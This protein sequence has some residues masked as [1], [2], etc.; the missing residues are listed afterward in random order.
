ML[1]FSGCAN[2]L[3]SADK[4]NV[5][6]ID[7]LT[8][9]TLP[10]PPKEKTITKREDIKKVMDVVNLIKKEKMKSDNTRGWILSIHT[11]GKEKHSITFSGGKVVIDKLSYKINLWAVFSIVT[12]VYLITLAA[13]IIVIIT[14]N[15]ERGSVDIHRYKAVEL[16]IY[17]FLYGMKTGIAEEILFRGFIAKKL[18]KRFGFSKGNV[19]QAIA[20][21]IPHFV[22]AG[23]ASTADIIV[24]IINAF[25]LGYV[26]G[27]IMDRKCD[28]SIIPC[29]TS[30]I[31]INMI[32]SAVMSI[33]L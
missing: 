3:V 24:R 30:H 10:S 25:L 15:S 1:I 11:S 23:S 18:I 19:V 8:I 16:F 17:L 28:G 26:F 7:S 9:I 27:Y 6:D 20:F 31:L 14:G 5:N 32:S 13:N 22:I 21:A 29:M 12:T 4:F 2:K 33:I